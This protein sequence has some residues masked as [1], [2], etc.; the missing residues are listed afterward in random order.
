MSRNLIAIFCL[1]FLAA[2]NATPDAKPSVDYQLGDIIYQ[3]NFDELGDWEAFGYL[4]AQ[5]GVSEGVYNIITPGG[6]YIPITNQHIHRNVVMEVKTEQRSP[7]NNIVY[8]IMCR[9]Q[10][11]NANIGYYF[12]ITASGQYG[13]RVGEGDRVRMEVPWTEHPAIKTGLGATNLLRAVCI[14]DY[15][16]LYINDVFVAESRYDWLEEGVSAFVVNAAPEVT[17]AIQY[18][19]FKIWDASLLENP[20]D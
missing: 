9:S 18:D 16:A 12:L 17:I 19:D 14:E 15:L 6:G 4:E 3:T 7:D 1:L 13:I 5:F 8:G 2:C 20:A 11:V 10:L